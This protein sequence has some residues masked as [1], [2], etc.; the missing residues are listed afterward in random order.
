MHN[1]INKLAWSFDGKKLAAGDINGHIN[2]FSSEKDVINVKGEDVN[3][4]Y[5]S[6]EII[7]EDCIKQLEKSK[8][9]KESL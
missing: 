9:K 3:K 8:T 2:I 1:A 6:I 5:N 4:F 7:K